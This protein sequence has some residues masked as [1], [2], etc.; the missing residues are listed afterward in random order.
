MKVLSLLILALFS[1]ATKGSSFEGFEEISAPVPQTLSNILITSVCDG[2][3]GANSTTPPTMFTIVPTND[4]VIK[5][6]SSPKVYTD[7]IEQDP[8]NIDVLKF[9]VDP[10]VANGTESGGV[11]IHFP[12]SKLELIFVERSNTARVTDGFTNIKYLGVSQ[13]ARMQAELTSLR[14]EMDNVLVLT[15]GQMSLKSNKGVDTVYVSGNG[16]LDLEA[17]VTDSTSVDS[18]GKLRMKGNINGYSCTIVFGVAEVEGDLNVRDSLVT[19]FATLQFVN[20]ISTPVSA[21]NVGGYITAANCGSIGDCTEEPA[22]TVTV[23]IEEK[24]PTMALTG[25]CTGICDDLTDVWDTCELPTFV[26][27][28]GPDSPPGFTSGAGTLKS[29]ILSLSLALISGMFLLHAN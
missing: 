24:K 22:P 25:L 21:V 15:G 27:G 26:A 4:N 28:D 8:F 12:V 5:V 3:T 1:S 6:E 11:I 29:Q 20:A 18:G 17:D 13:S 19:T 9:V 10:S 14:D 16:E 23:T 7:S 2:E